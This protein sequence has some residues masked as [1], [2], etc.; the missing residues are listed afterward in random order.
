MGNFANVFGPAI[1][2]T[3]SLSVRRDVETELRCDHNSAP[4]W[5]ERF[6]DQ[7]LIIEWA[8]NFS[9]IEKRHTAI[10]GSPQTEIIS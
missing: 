9:R 5:S 2:A 3:K 8:V 4:N 6:A 7:L 10:Y 1:R